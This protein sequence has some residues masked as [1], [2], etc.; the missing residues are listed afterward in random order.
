MD[1]YPIDNYEQLNIL[2]SFGLDILLLISVSFMILAG[3][4]YTI[5]NRWDITTVTSMGISLISSVIFL[6]MYLFLVRNYRVSIIK[7][8]EKNIA[9]IDCELAKINKYIIDKQTKPS[10]ELEVLI[11]KGKYLWKLKKKIN[12]MSCFPYKIKGFFVSIS[13]I[14]PV[15]LKIMPQ[16]LNTFF[17]LEK[18]ITIL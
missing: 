9:Q 16:F 13:P 1:E 12:N 5:H 7:Y 6:G 8:K 4:V 10:K 14:A 18:F 3:N 2:C 11:K 15:L 17:K